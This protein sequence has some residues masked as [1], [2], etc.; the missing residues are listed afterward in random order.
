MQHINIMLTMCSWLWGTQY[1]IKHVVV[2]I[3]EEHHHQPGQLHIPQADI[4]SFP[5]PEIHVC[6]EPVRMAEKL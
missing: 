2:L 1:P 3:A 5:L 4:Q 6:R